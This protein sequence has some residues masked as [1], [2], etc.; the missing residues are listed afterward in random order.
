[1]RVGFLV[2]K[3]S[4]M[5]VY[6]P[7][8]KEL[9]ARGH[10]VVLLCGGLKLQNKMEIPGKHSIHLPISDKLALTHFDT[11]EDLKSQNLN[12][13]FLLQVLDPLYYAIARL[14]QRGVKVWG[15]QYLHE[16]VFNF[17]PS[18]LE[19]MDGVFVHNE[20]AIHSYCD[21]YNLSRDVVKEKFFIVG[22]PMLDCLASI[23]RGQLR[24]EYGVPDHR[25]AVLFLHPLNATLYDKLVFGTDNR[26]LSLLQVIGAAIYLKKS[27]LT[28]Y[29]WDTLSGVRYRDILDAIRS[30]KKREGIYLIGKSRVKHQD[31]SYV[32]MCCDRIITEGS[33]SW[34]PFESLRL[35][36]LS[37]LC[38]GFSSAV[39]CEAAAVGV[40]TINVDILDNWR[41]E[42]I[43]HFSKP[44][45]DY[46]V[47][48]GLWDWPNVVRT[49]KKS[50][51]VNFFN[52]CKLEEFRLDVKHLAEYRQRF[53]GCLDGRATHRIADYV[54]ATVS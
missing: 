37:D 51:A 32:N 41:D 43:T 42:L 1:M 52:K 9:S 16:H 31:H 20:F 4:N 46:F 38:I 21:I 54:E 53:T 18:A 28:R 6:A 26:F 50:E 8:I 39:V 15:I 3:S 17:R 2:H 34:Y 5:K 36:S 47:R 35:L 22:N 48:A 27:Y 33:D 25:V 14:Y 23:D 40:Y 49:V 30:F 10:E 24:Q 29:T 7:I 44:A 45:V 12:V 19:I 11:P 13:L